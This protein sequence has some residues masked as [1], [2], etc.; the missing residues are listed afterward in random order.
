MSPRNQNLNPRLDG[1]LAAYAAVAGA[2]LAAP[3]IPN[4]DADIVYSGPVNVNI[5]STTQ[6]VYLNVVSGIN[7]TNSSLVASWDVNPWSSTGLGLFNP[8]TPSQAYVATAAGG[9]T[10][11][12]MAFGAM[13]D[14]SSLYG[15]NSSA[16]NAQWNLNSSNNL[17]GF[18]FVDPSIGGGATTLY[19]WMRISLSATAG[20]QPRA[21]VEYAYENTGAGI[22]AGVPEPSTMALLGVM[23]AGALGVRAW[24]K[25]KAA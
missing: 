12:N 19:G 6:G 8:A 3:A 24:R 20:S 2:A 22:Q 18:R 5:T 14:G 4:A 10:A 25:R 11:V 1:R 7:S 21:I 17:V 23:A 9:T 16:N 15:S 13:I